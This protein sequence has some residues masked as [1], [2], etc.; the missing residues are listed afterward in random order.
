MNALILVNGELG[1]SDVLR[2]RIHR[3]IF[4]LVCA[5]DGGAQHAGALGIAL[6]VIV[7]D[8]DSCSALK[9]NPEN[10]V[11]LVTYPAEKNETDL[12]LAMHYAKGQGADRIVLVGVM[13]G[14]LDMAI[15]NILLI[16]NTS[17][18]SGR[19][20]IWE[21]KQ[22][23]WTI[24]PPGDFIGGQPGDTVS[25]IPLGGQ[26]S[27][28]TITGFKYPLNDETLLPGTPRGISNVM[29]KPEAHVKFSGGVLLVI[30]TPGKI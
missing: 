8:M 1:Q 3:E 12:E 16:S 23:A 25:L 24:N 19:I 29:E 5:A 27:G 21:G 6:D 18:N 17:L 9:L 22:T 14:R 2:D 11:K 10:H 30:H 4:G 20:E 26:A 28:I 15:A 7:G 13:G